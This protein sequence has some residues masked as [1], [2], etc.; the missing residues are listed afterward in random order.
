MSGMV[1]RIARILHADQGYP[2]WPTPACTQCMDMARN[3][4]EEMREP[5]EAM[6]WA[7]PPEPYMDGDVWAKMID[8]AL[9]EPNP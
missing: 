5:T 8:A 1:E 3:I 9:A 2:T 7:G 4:L 6:L